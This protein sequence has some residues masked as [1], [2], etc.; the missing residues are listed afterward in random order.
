MKFESAGSNLGVF[1]EFLEAP[2]GIITPGATGSV[3]QNTDFDPSEGWFMG[4]NGD[5]AITSQTFLANGVLWQGLL[6]H[7]GSPNSLDIFTGVWSRFAI[8]PDLVTGL[9]QIRVSFEDYFDPQD[10]V[11][12]NRFWMI[13]VQV[14]HEYQYQSYGHSG[15]VAAFGRCRGGVPVVRDAIL[16]RVLIP[17]YFQNI[18]DNSADWQTIDGSDFNF[19]MNFGPRDLAAGTSRSYGHLQSSIQGN[20]SFPA[21]PDVLNNL[22]SDTSNQYDAWGFAQGYRVAIGCWPMHN[23]NFGSCR[24]QKFELL[25]GGMIYK[26]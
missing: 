15:I 12:A 16:T 25:Q 8:I 5:P 22:V 4:V 23:S 18:W 21:V 17:N 13:G 7:A 2:S 14:A 19:T 26:P 24:L 6:P 20:G 1:G 10:Q 3:L 11:G 9:S